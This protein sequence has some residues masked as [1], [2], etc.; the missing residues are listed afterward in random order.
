M[1]RKLNYVLLVSLIN[2]WIRGHSARDARCQAGPAIFRVFGRLVRGS[3][4]KSCLIDPVQTS[5]GG[6]PAKTGT[7]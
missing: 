7:A 6:H 2:S 4:P 3:L 5:P 1:A